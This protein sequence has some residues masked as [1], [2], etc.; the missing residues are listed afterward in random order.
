MIIIQWR[1]QGRAPPPPHTT[2]PPLFLD[3]TEAQK[4]EKVYFLRPPPF[5]LDVWIRYCYSR[6]GKQAENHPNCIWC[7]VIGSSFTVRGQLPYF[8]PQT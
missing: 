2:T 1:V 7:D 4:A 3:Q 5:Y 8:K 6:V